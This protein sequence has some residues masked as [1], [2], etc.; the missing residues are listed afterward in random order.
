MC[1]SVSCTLFCQFCVSYHVLCVIP[2]FVFCTMFC[3]SYH[4]LCVLPCFV[5]HTV[6]CRLH[7]VLCV[8]P[9]FVCCT[10]FCL[11][12]HVLSVVSRFVCCT[13]F[14][15]KTIHTYFMNLL[16]TKFIFTFSSI[17]I[18]DCAL[19]LFSHPCMTIF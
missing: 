3:V 19:F 5:C 7:H 12:Y 4:V 9:C 15:L 17:L 18:D 1:L 13:I 8:V 14:C 2:R 10:M 16:A 11:L 6:F